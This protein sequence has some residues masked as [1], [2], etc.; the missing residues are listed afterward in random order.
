MEHVNFVPENVGYKKKIKKKKKKKIQCL[1]LFLK[2]SRSHF[3]HFLMPVIR[4]NFRKK[5]VN[6]F[7]KTSRV[8]ILG[9]KTHLL[10]FEHEHNMNFP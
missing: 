8:L 3:T 4:Y 10:H 2:N 1:L 5:P 6:R 9:P 7:K